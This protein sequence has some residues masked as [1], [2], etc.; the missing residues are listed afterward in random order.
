MRVS[1][2]LTD[3]FS[4]SK[5]SCAS[6]CLRKFWYR[7]VLGKRENATY[8]LYGRAVH[9][10]QETDNEAKLQGR[11]LRIAEVLDSAVEAL[12]TESEREAV[13]VDLDPFAAEHRR[14]L[15]LF[16]A[17]GERAKIVPVPG[18]VEAAFGIDLEVA[19]GPEEPK[20]PCKLTGFVDVVSQRA[21]DQPKEV[22]DYKTGIKPVY[23]ADANANLQFALYSMAAEAAGCRA[24]SFVKGGK[25]K[26]TVKTTRLSPLT[27]TLKE[28]L[29]TWIADNVHAIRRCVKSG[30]FPKCDPGCFWCGPTS[31]DF[32][33]LCYGPNPELSKTIQV[34]GL[35]PVGTM[36]QPEWRKK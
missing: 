13:K 18:T 31:C 6:K 11:V 26:A 3:S 16:E 22:I 4:F 9:R 15:E 36:E 24:I 23:Q 30:D 29:L 20:I 27:P 2:L 7:Y 14:Q 8:M 19:G 28:K 35:K 21:P 17:S 25:Q 33:Q 1:E 12:R 10:G 32:Y 5:L 34:T